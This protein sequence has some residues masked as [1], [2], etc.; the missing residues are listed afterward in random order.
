[1]DNIHVNISDG[2]SES[3][4]ID[5]EIEEEPEPEPEPEQQEV[6]QKKIK[7]EHRKQG[8]TTAG[9]PPRLGVSDTERKSKYW[10][11]FHDTTNVGVIKC[12]YCSKLIRAS[13]RNGTSVFKN[14][15]GKV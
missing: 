8:T 1:M 15:L 12:K 3:E 10:A 7:K 14:H 9:K 13:S 6:L 4:E 5:I 11:H 2:E